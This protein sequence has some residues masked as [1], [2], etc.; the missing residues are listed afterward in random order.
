MKL[1]KCDGKVL[2]VR[3]CGPVI[4]RLLASAVPIKVNGWQLM[5]DDEARKLLEELRD[6]KLYAGGRVRDEGRA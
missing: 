1:V 3:D 4:Y 2:E 5:T 6:L